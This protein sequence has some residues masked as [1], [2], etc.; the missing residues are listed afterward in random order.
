MTR[1]LSEELGRN[2]H[3]LWDNFP[4]P[5]MLTREDRTVLDRNKAAEAVGCTPGTR[6]VELGRKEDHAGCHAN[7][8]LR[9]QTAKRVIGYVPLP[10]G[11]RHLLD[12]AGRA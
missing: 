4:F 5:V 7:E 1:A 6:C 8:A 9:E 11:A 12:P 2:F 10:E 3:V